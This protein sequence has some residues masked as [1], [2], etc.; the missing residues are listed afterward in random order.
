MSQSNSSLSSD[1]ETVS[2][3]EEEIM[4]VD[5]SQDEFEPESTRTTANEVI[6]TILDESEKLEQEAKSARRKGKQR[7]SKRDVKYQQ[8][9]A[10][11]IEDMQTEINSL[12]R[13]RRPESPA[14]ESSKRTKIDVD[15]DTGAFDRPS[16]SGFK[17]PSSKQLSTGQKPQL[18]SATIS[19]Q[20]KTANSTRL[21]PKKSVPKQLSPE[22]RPERSGENVDTSEE[23]VHQN[24]NDDAITIQAGENDDPLAQE[25]HA[26][27]GA[28]NDASDMDV[29]SAEED[30][31]N[32]FEDMVDAIDIRGEDDLPGEP[33]PQTWAE[34]VNLAWKTKVAKGVF[35]VLLQ[36]YKTPSNL[37]AFK[38]PKMNSEMWRL[39]GKWQ[40]KADL[41]LSGSQRALMKAATAVLKM[42]DYFADTPRSTR[43]VAMQT[44]ADVISLL[45]KVNRDITLKR[46]TMIRPSLKGDFK[47]LST[48]TQVTVMFG[49]N[50]TQA[51]K[52]IQV[53]RK[54]EDP[55][56]I[57]SSSNRFQN[58]RNQRG[59]NRFN[60]SN[61][62]SYAGNFLWR[63]RGR[64]RYHHRASHYQQNQQH[65]NGP[66]K[67]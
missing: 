3:S 22:K 6:A 50:L 42:H 65:Q 66:K 30:E 5:V 63:G 2:Y 36:K 24:V 27:S 44:A 25:L 12:K 16:S 47:T 4:D 62:N 40:R 23:T 17:K 51:I 13:S 38:V 28:A 33:L 46:K 31:D 48:S 10:K 15:N 21:S 8:N 14:S 19:K 60:N 11:L 53:K 43:Q 64:G 37:T 18:S 57:S 9:F 67:N 61:N 45:G 7:V 55:S 52:D 39:I 26:N 59:N 34:K 54:I 35:N 1:E 58:R 56:S 20:L 41:S 32:I 29:T 49:D